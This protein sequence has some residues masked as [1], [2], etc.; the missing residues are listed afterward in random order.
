LYSALHP[1]WW[2]LLP[3]LLVW[4]AAFLAIGFLLKK[5]W[6]PGIIAVVCVVF[7]H[8]LDNNIKDGA[9]KDLAAAQHRI[10]IQLPD[11]KIGSE[12]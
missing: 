6:L 12:K 2:T 1:P 3:M 10:N 7:L 5:R 11:Y 9:A 4:L 8:N